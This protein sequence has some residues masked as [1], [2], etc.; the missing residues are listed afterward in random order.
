[1]ATAKDQELV[2]DETLIA[3]IFP[4]VHDIA[5]ADCR[6]I[7]N[8]WE[9]CTF[10]VEFAAAPLPNYPEHLVV[11][12]ETAGK[13][14]AAVSALQRLAH[15]QLPGLVPSVLDVGTTAAADRRKLADSVTVFSANTT[16]L[17]DVWDSLDPTHQAEL[18]DSV[19]KA[20]RIG[21]PALGYFPDIQQFLQG[22]LQANS[23]KTSVCELLE[24]GNGGIVLRSKFDDLGSMDLTAQDL[25]GLQR[26]VV[27]CHNDLEPR[28][29][30]VRNVSRPDDPSPRH[31]LAAI[32][33]WEMAGF[34]PFAYESGLKDCVLGSSNLSFTWYSLFKERTAHL[35]P[36]TECHT[37][38]MGC[39][40]LIF[41]SRLR[42]M[43][44]NVGVR[45]Q[46]KWMALH[47]LERSSDALALGG[48]VR[49][50]PKPLGT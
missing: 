22:V 45:V 20:R 10:S 8:A 14:L 15:A 32:I 37:K 39:L 16:T 12:L 48:F 27:F 24:V 23:P 44:R 29:I 1:M 30:L 3:S 11:R 21:G 18:A 31:E 38:F 33:D 26:H 4:G 49:L 5:A 28:N 19:V 9:T 36:E 42:N 43:S 25:D 13:R 47:R 40:R 35:L 46:A 6:V 41:E 50:A 7:A 2:P 17:E 34:Y